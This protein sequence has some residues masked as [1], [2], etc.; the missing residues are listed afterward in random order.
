M[1]HTTPWQ[2]TPAGREALQ[3]Y[4]TDLEYNS[5]SLVAIS[6]QANFRNFIYRS[7]SHSNDPYK[8]HVHLHFSAHAGSTTFWSDSTKDCVKADVGT[9]THSLWNDEASNIHARK[10]EILLEQRGMYPTQ[11]EIS[12]ASSHHLNTQFDFIDN[13][14]GS[15]SWTP[16]ET[17]LSRSH[18]QRNTFSTFATLNPH[19]CSYK[20]NVNYSSLSISKM[21][22]AKYFAEKQHVSIASSS[23]STARILK[24]L[25][26]F[27]V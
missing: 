25:L 27:V 17:T 14:H 16:R 24:R 19:Y 15:G 7:K 13:S 9:T 4:Q 18:S 5:W 20:Q 23:K 11:T 6:S 10:F 26:K 12:N 22:A 3:V 21:L 1:S 2:E 8:I